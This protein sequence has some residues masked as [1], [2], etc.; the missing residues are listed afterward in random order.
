MCNNYTLFSHIIIYSIMKIMRF[1]SFTNA[2]FVAHIYFFREKTI[3]RITQFRRHNYLQYMDEKSDKTRNL[4][5]VFSHEEIGVVY[6]Y[7]VTAVG[8]SC[9]GKVVC[10]G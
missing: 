7:W 4:S 6:S 2:R 10:E 5:T 3:E 9:K 1:N 8:N